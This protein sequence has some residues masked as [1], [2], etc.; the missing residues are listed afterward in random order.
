MGVYILQGSTLVYTVSQ[1]SVFSLFSVGVVENV[2]DYEGRGRVMSVT[3]GTSMNKK[4]ACL[5]DHYVTMES[6]GEMPNY[7]LYRIVTFCSKCGENISHL[8]L[9][10][11]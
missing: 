8:N 6:Q 10:K 2:S 1:E 3:T 7:L 4:K 5:H 9:L 11:V